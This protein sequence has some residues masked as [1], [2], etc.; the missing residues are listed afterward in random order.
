MKI[1]PVMLLTALVVADVRMSREKFSRGSEALRFA[2]GSDIGHGLVMEEEIEIRR[3]ITREENEISPIGITVVTRESCPFSEAM[4][5]TLKEHNTAYTHIVAK[6]T[7]K[8]DSLLKTMRKY[9]RR[10]PAVYVD[11]VYIGGYTKSLMDETFLE[12]LNSKGV[13]SSVRES[14]MLKRPD[15]KS[16]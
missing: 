12:L 16:K 13:R 5:R 11:G 14:K 15:S 2:R 7:G 10:F 9:E 6:D 1:C 8:G 3:A 4:L